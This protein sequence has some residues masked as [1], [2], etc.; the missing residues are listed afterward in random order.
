MFSF[1]FI[2]VV[3]RTE[4]FEPVLAT[5]PEQLLPVQNCKMNEIPS[6]VRLFLPFSMLYFYFLYAQ[7]AL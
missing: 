4:L 1:D 7:A 5:K 3:M 2:D 6:V